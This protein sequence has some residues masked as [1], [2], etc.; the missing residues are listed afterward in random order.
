MKKEKFVIIFLIIVLFALNIFL[1]F[2]NRNNKIIA[3]QYLEAFGNYQI[4]YFLQ[5]KAFDLTINRH[6]LLSFINESEKKIINNKRLVIYVPKESCGICLDKLLNRYWDDYIS[7][8]VKRTIILYE[9]PY[10]ANNIYF[11]GENLID[12]KKMK[13]LKIKDNNLLTIFFLD[14]EQRLLSLYLF[15]PHLLDNLE[16]YLKSFCNYLIKPDKRY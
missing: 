15:D 10:L 3:R 13:E 14:N 11:L 9:D 4:E 16:Y 12:H 6:H 2:F 5:R 7:K 1:F 8:I